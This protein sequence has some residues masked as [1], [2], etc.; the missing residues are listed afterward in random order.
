MPIVITLSHFR[1][2]HDALRETFLKVISTGR[3]VGYY[4]YIHFYRNFQSENKQKIPTSA[5]NNNVN[6]LILD[7]VSREK[8]NKKLRFADPAFKTS[9]IYTK[10][11]NL[12]FKPRIQIWRHDHPS[13]TYNLSSCEITAWNNWF[14]VEQDS[15]SWPT[16]AP[17]T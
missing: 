2:L 1:A 10:D 11:H 7:R 5:V 6:K 16:H 3:G 4:V 8:L 12:I 17:P 9:G 14:R 13:Y 15:N